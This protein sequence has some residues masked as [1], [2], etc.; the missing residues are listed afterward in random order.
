MSSAFTTLPH[1]GITAHIG[2]LGKN[3]CHRSE[4]EAVTTIQDARDEYS[5][6]HSTKRNGDYACF[7]IF[8]EV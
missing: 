8:E 3:D 4:A 2:T 6:G 7:C 1:V 5:S